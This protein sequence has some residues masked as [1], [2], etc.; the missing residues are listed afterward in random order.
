MSQYGAEFVVLTES[1]CTDVVTN[2]QTVVRLSEQANRY[3]YCMLYAAV[4]TR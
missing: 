1:L 2:C 4:I 3:K